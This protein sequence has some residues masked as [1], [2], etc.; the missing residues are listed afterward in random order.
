MSGES[1]FFQLYCGRW[2]HRR[3]FIP[4]NCF[5]PGLE[6]EA[7]RLTGDLCG[8]LPGDRGQGSSQGGFYLGVGAGGRS[9]WKRNDQGSRG[10]FPSPHLPFGFV[11]NFKK[12]Q[13][14]LGDWRRGLCLRSFNAGGND[15]EETPDYF[16]AKC[17]SRH[18]QQNLGTLG[19]PG[20][21]LL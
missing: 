20:S 2:G 8:N 1:I 18:D 19:G 6:A 5:G 11:S 4:G 13:T 3:T 7:G 14:G 15:H 9:S 10:A 17:D 16:G 21:G 12:G